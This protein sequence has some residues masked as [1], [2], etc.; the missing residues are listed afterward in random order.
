MRTYLV[1]R[2]FLTV[3]LLLAVVT[4]A[5]LLVHLIPGD[6]AAVLAGDTASIEDVQAMRMALGLDRPLLEQYGR[7]LFRLFT[8][9]SLGDSIFLKM[10]VTKAIAQRLEPTMILTSLSAFISVAL[11]I[12]LG[13]WAAVRHNTWVDRLLMLVALLGLSVP[14]FWLG[15]NLSLIFGLWLKV[16]PV[17]GY[18]PLEEGLWQAVRY[19][20]LPALA[21]GFSGSAL[22]A[23]MMRSSML[24]VLQLDYIRTARSKG[25]SQRLVVY[26]HALR[27]AMLPTLTVIGLSIAGLAGGAVIIETVFSVPGAGMLVI[28][29]IA[30]RDYPVVQ[31]TVLFAA[32]L[33]L[34]INLAIDLLYSYIDPRVR[35]E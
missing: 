35:Y 9:F 10:P 22:I 5:F 12:P 31:G 27:N 32:M 25:L 16:L 6:P 8:K 11:G 21:L 30:R 33:Y 13:I 18:A 3:P 7:F 14:N 4:I 2:L 15:L 19:M 17:A 20:L 23:R 26:R 34:F 28:N 24:D 29:A 1:R